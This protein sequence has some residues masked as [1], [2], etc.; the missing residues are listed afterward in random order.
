MVPTSLLK[1]ILRGCSRNRT[2]NSLLRTQHPEIKWKN[3]EIK[4]VKK[5][6][7]KKSL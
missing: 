3:P 2:R 1:R 6:V 7:R 5:P 4:Q